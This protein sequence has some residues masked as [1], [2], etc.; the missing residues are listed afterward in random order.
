VEESCHAMNEAL[1]KI[2]GEGDNEIEIFA[3]AEV[4]RFRNGHS[5]RLA[6]DYGKI[7]SV[8]AFNFASS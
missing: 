1:R 3:L 2:G 7:D 6:Q 5:R 4:R 8:R